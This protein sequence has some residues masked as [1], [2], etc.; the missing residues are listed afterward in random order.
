MLEKG[1]GVL[2]LSSLLEKQRVS[3]WWN[4]EVAVI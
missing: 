2:D 3:L 1:G 4:Q